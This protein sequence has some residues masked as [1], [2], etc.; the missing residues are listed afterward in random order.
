MTKPAAASTPLIP[1]QR[2]ELI[3][4]HLRREGVL[5]YRQLVDLVGVSH[6]T[7]RRDISVLEE[8]GRV[9][10]TPGGAKI[11]SRLIAEPT[12]LEKA[13]QDVAEKDDMAR[14]AAS[15]VRES[16]TIYLDAGTTIQAMRPHLESVNDL[17]IVTNDLAIIAA[18][19]D[20]PTAD[21]IAVGGRVEK[22]NQST[23]GH[24]AALALNELSIDI[25]FLSSSS[26]DLRRGVT[27]PTESKIAPKTAALKS[28][29]ESVLVAGSSKYGT[30][31]R[32]RVFELTELDIIITDAGL[33]EAAAAGIE[34]HGIAVVR[35]TAV[36]IP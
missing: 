6:M 12:R 14:H 28:A 34:E 36:D 22:A 5:S 18:F 33:S 11:A 35:T 30:F 7:V 24:L 10:A 17:T 16:M 32:Y 13:E 15:L 2:R 19:L 3:V 9:L 23:T 29:S 20:H 8:A 31:G 21:L 1:E 27:T 26:W 4:K 25:A